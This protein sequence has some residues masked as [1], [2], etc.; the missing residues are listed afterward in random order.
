MLRDQE[1]MKRLK[2]ELE[3]DTKERGFYVQQMT[4]MYDKKIYGY[5]HFAEIEEK[6]RVM[7]ISK[8]DVLDQAQKELLRLEK[9]CEEQSAKIKKLTREN[10]ALR[11]RGFF[12]RLLNREDKF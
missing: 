7:I 8:D 1:D 2:R 3:A 5:E 10:N 9:M 4:H 11:C 12:A 6:S